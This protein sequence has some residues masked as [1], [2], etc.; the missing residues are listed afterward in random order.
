MK[1]WKAMLK[2]AKMGPQLFG[3]L[4]IGN[5]SCAVGAVCLS[6]GFMKAQELRNKFPFLWDLESCP[7]SGCCDIKVQTLNNVIVHLNDNHKWSRENIAH[8]VRSIEDPESF[9][10]TKDI[11]H[12]LLAK[13]I[14]ND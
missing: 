8:W 4:K 2:G 13:V 11:H 3:R 14:C 6:M 12:E 1:M 5:G 9:I 7:V 10:K